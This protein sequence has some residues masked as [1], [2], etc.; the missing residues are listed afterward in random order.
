LSDVPDGPVIIIANEFLDALPVHQA[1]MCADGWHE[2][3]VKIGDHDNF[4]FSIERDP[5]PLFDELLPR[6]LRAAKIGQIF[7]WRPDQA[8]LELGRRVVQ[9]NGVA[10]VLD[11]GHTQSAVGETLQAVA[12]HGFADPLVM[13]GEV[14]LTAHV[15]FQAIVRAAE[16]MR[17]RCHGPIE[18]AELLRRL[19]IEERAAVLK[20]GATHEQATAVQAGLVRLTNRERTGMGRMVKALG[21]SAPRIGPLPGFG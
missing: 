20:S 13:P 16:S 15:D 5:I 3:V 17:A 4:H 10:L 21:L 8:A 11:Y 1:V 14:D 9:S 19:G 6:H 18:Q 2:R 12:G 7:E